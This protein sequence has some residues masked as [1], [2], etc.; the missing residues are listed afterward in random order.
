MM[1]IHVFAFFL[2]MLKDIYLFGARFVVEFTYSEAR[3]Q[4]WWAF[5]FWHTYLHIFMHIAL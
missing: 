4:M 2:H 3:L 1:K 5:T